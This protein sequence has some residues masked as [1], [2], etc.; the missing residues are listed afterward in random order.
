MAS[1]GRAAANPRQ[2]PAGLGTQIPYLFDELW[3]KTSGL[4]IFLTVTHK[5]THTHTHMHTHV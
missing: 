4:Q 1:K 3:V 2:V 5:R